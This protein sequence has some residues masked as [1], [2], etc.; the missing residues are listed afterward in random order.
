MIKR[1]SSVTVTTI[2]YSCPLPVPRY[3]YGYR[4]G[5]GYGLGYGRGYG[6]GIGFGI[7]V[8][9]RYT[10]AVISTVLKRYALPD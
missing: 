8:A 5:L 10:G 4:Y 6:F 1:F 7:G 3:G 9:T 2:G